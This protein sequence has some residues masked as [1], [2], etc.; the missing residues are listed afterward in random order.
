MYHT[1]LD[2]WTFTAPLSVG[3]FDIIL[4]FSEIGVPYKFGGFKGHKNFVY[5]QGLF[6]KVQRLRYYLNNSWVNSDLWLLENQSKSH[7]KSPKMHQNYFLL[8][9]V[10]AVTT[11]L[12]KKHESTLLHTYIL[13]KFLTADHAPQNIFEK[14]S[15]KV[16]SSHIYASFGTF[17]VQ[18]DQLFKAQ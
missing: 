6:V 13:N 4:H 10:Y 5:K 2:F 7:E 15:K 17:Y 1:E 12:C 9:P 16:G 11:M 8:L 18:I 3:I 14:N